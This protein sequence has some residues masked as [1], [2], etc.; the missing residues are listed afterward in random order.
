MR[1]SCKAG[2]VFWLQFA[3]HGT[4]IKDDNGDEGHA[5]GGKDECIVTADYKLKSDC[6]IR[7]DWLKDNLVEALKPD[8]EG[9]IFNDCCHSGTLFDEGLPWN[10]DLESQKWQP[11]KRGGPMDTKCKGKVLYLSGAQDPEKAK[12]LTWKN[13]DVITKRGG[14][15]TLMFLETVAEHGDE[16]TL[17]DLLNKI[18]SKVRKRNQRPQLYCTHKVDVNSPIHLAMDGDCSTRR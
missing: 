3:G 12:E 11:W 17:I 2:D 8:V 15:V 16:I 7:D 4:R 10:L 1:D 14:A 6:Y 9:M 5:G 18:D 13:G